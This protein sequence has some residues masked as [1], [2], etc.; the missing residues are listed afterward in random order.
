MV[1]PVPKW[2]TELR[3]QTSGLDHLGLGSVSNQRILV[4]LVPDLFVLTAHPA[5]HSFYSFVL[6]E[7]WRRDDLPRTRAAW[8]R[9][10]RSR[11]L[12]FSIAC[13][14]CEHPD[15]G[16][17]FANIVGSGKTADLA[18]EPPRGGYR[19]DVDFIKSPFGGYGLYYRS[20]MS[21]MGLVYLQQD[22][23]YPVDVPSA[24]GKE[25]AARF[26]E[27]ISATRYWKRY[28][29]AD[30]VPE[31]AVREYGEAACLCRLR[32]GAPDLHAVRD[33]VLHGGLA[34]SAAGRRSSLRM[35]LD[36]AD[37]TDGAPL[38][39]I[40]FR[41]LIYYG[42]DED[43]AEWEASQDLE[44]P[45][46]QLSIVDI[47]RRWRLYQARE[48]YSYALDGLWR[49]L[50]DWGIENNGDAHPTPI[51]DAVHALRASLDPGALAEAVGSPVSDL[52]SQTTVGRAVR[53]LRKLAGEPAIFPIH[54]EAWP[55]RRFDVD[56]EMTE[57]ALYVSTN[58]GAVEPQVMATA[59]L[60]LLL[61]AATRFDHLPHEHRDD[62]SYARAGGIQR[63]SFDRF[64]WS[65]R[66]R[67]TEKATVGEVAEWVL[68]DYV[69]AQHLRV[70]N[71]KLPYNTFRFV[72][73]GNSLRF[74]DRTRPINMNSA[75]F[76]ALS[77]TVSDLGFVTP[78]ALEQHPLTPDGRTFLE[79]GD[80]IGEP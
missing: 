71:S 45:P 13:N 77:H 80:W 57:W 79:T 24:V 21:S 49:W 69:V 47:W 50:V 5:Y 20:I 38:D 63:L 6:D 14:T 56:A 70:A 61:L 46:K 23:S 65:L 58:R 60:A 33:V 42:R 75:R 11:E 40:S 3:E 39:Q 35:L 26:R 62:W 27:R 34:A 17:E 32:D 37:S 54:D 76:V 73:E 1:D 74:F 41:Q 4:N 30:R 67:A 25:L 29:D 12:I 36:I 64:I 66:R 10:Y 59:C 48:F 31:A 2:T 51:G 8:Q 44:T 53:S 55:D 9:F 72:L 52:G 68:R 22:T 18:A 15:Y 7:Y 78:L 28:F 16:G 43:G 19:T